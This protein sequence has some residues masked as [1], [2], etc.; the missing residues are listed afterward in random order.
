MSGILGLAFCRTKIDN[1]EEKIL[2][3]PFGDA[4]IKHLSSMKNSLPS[5]AARLALLSLIQI[6]TSIDGHDL[7]IKRDEY[8]K[9]HFTSFPLHFSLSHSGELA[10]AAISDV[11]LGIDL[12]MHSERKIDRIA[13]RFFSDA[14]RSEIKSLEDDEQLERFYLTWTKKEALSKLDGRGIS[15]LSSLST[16][17]GAFISYEALDG[18]HK[19]S[20]SIALPKNCEKEIFIIETPNLENNNIK[21]L[22]KQ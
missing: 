1:A 22:Q 6:G 11:P 18:N 9:P 4:D 19:Y 10:V 3:L 16:D 2:A 7:T 21:L 13:K 8:G 5:L 20:L 12:E 15:A 17:G 14:Q